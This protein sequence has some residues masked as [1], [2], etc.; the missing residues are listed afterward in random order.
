MTYQCPQ[1]SDDF[2]VLAVL[3]DPTRRALLD[4]LRGKP[5]P[6]GELARQMPVSRPAVSQHLRILKEAQL[7]RE[8]RHGTRHYFGLNPAGFAGLREYADSMWQEAL[9]AFAAYVAE[10]TRG[11]TKSGPR[12]PAQ[13]KERNDKV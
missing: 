4:L 7:V 11:A 10:Q 8:H 1:G 2:P 6:V 3:A 9:N 12:R 13:E 5:L